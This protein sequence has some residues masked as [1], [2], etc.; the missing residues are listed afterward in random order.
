MSVPNVSFGFSLS[1]RAVAIGRVTAKQ[2]IDVAVAAEQSGEIDS[3]WVG[4]SIV[5]KPRLEAVT[6]LA[7]IAARTE[8]VKLGTACM[9]TFIMRNP[10]IF[11][12][13]WASLD[14]ISSG[15][16]L[17]AVCLG[18]HGPQELVDREF[19]TFGVTKKER[20]PRMLE[21]MRILR[22]LWSEDSVTFEGRFH[23]F[24]NV[25]I[26]PRP[27]QQPCPIWIANNPT[28]PAIMEKAYRRVARHADGWMTGS[29]PADVF[30]DRWAMLRQLRTEEKGSAE[31]FLSSNHLR[32]NVNDDREAAYGEAKEFLDT[33]YSVNHTR[34]HLER[35]C[36]IGTPED[37]I[38]KFVAY[39]K[40]GCDIIMIRLLSWHPEEQVER[41]VNDIIPEVRRR[42]SAEQAA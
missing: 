4:D 39:A 16:S 23:S 28:D 26:G 32:S 3:L 14:S 34:E 9:A 25:T 12:H 2:M 5:A 30:A 33:Y 13:Q 8:K 27:I 19:E 6:A 20:V 24:S 7:A 31:G 29:L 38:Q 36:V 40:A 17:L 10:V 21:S 41:W 37:C 15:R 11:A 35:D 22:Q 1:N 42:L 18:G